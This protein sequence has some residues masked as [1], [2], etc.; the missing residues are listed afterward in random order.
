MSEESLSIIRQVEGRGEL[1]FQRQKKT[2]SIVSADFLCIVVITAEDR[3]QRFFR[4][5]VLPF[6][7]RPLLIN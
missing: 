1:L 3:E 2:F 5:I 4:K 7:F 6:Y